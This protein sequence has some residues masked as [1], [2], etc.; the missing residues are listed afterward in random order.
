[1]KYIKILILSVGLFSFTSALSQFNIGLYTGF[2]VANFSFMESDPNDP[3]RFGYSST[4][5]EASSFFQKKIGFILENVISERIALVWSLELA[6]GNYKTHQ[7]QFLDEPS[8]LVFEEEISER[9][10]GYKIGLGIDVAVLGEIQYDPIQVLINATFIQQFSVHQFDSE[11]KNVANREVNFLYSPYNLTTWEAANAESSFGTF[12]A[13]G[14]KVNYQLNDDIM[15]FL[16]G[17]YNLNIVSSD[18]GDLVHKNGFFLNI[19]V[20]YMVY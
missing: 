2:E 10:S 17:K 15:F 6:P 12:L 4:E 13:I 18:G 16:T 11:L 7:R 20:K 5:S 19:G 8:Q 9:M 1:M 3:I 14:P